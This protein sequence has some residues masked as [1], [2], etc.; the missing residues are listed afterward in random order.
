MAIEFNTF[1]YLF[2]FVINLDYKRDLKK[3][4]K[5]YM[6]PYVC[7]WYEFRAIEMWVDVPEVLF[8]PLNLYFV[9][10]RFF[11]FSFLFHLFIAGC[12]VSSTLR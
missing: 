3:K 6:R 9:L 11:F 8:G 4:K 10:S 2:L 7:L 1:I 12:D 5:N